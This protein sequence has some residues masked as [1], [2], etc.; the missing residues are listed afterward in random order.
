[1]DRHS[2]NRVLK[3]SSAA[4]QAVGK[5]DSKTIFLERIF[6]AKCITQ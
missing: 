6:A 3:T 2:I 4:L 5:S 1:M